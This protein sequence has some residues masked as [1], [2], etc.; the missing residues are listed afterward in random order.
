MEQMMTR[1]PNPEYTLKQI[2][3]KKENIFMR[4]YVAATGFRCFAKQYKYPLENQSQFFNYR[5]KI[6]MYLSIAQTCLQTF[7]L[8]YSY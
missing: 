1:M 4:F 8:L 5:D 6:R 2:K 7:M 3:F